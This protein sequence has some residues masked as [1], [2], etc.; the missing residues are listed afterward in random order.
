MDRRLRGAGSTVFFHR[1]KAFWRSCCQWQFKEWKHRGKR[2]LSAALLVL[3]DEA[4][5][6]RRP[7][8][9]RHSLCLCATTSLGTLLLPLLALLLRTRLLQWLLL[10]LLRLALR[11]GIEGAGKGRPAEDFGEVKGTPLGIQGLL[12]GREVGAQEA[13]AR[14]VDAQAHPDG[15]L[16]AQEPQE[17]RGDA[18]GLHAV[19]VRGQLLAHPHAQ[20]NAHHLLARNQRVVA[21]A[22]SPLAPRRGPIPA[23]ATGIA[24]GT[25]WA[26]RVSIGIPQPCAFSAST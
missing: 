16:V 6:L 11:L 1:E 15:A 9:I 14:L 13:E 12:P 7:E 19:H 8:I 20:V 21:P 5:Q 10:L 3:S 24:T 17:G 18:A 23:Q 22:R 26:Y 4:G 25:V 2:D